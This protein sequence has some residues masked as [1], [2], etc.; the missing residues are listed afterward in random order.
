MAFVRV[1]RNGTQDPG[2]CLLAKTK[3]PVCFRKRAVVSPSGLWGHCARRVSLQKP[4]RSRLRLTVLG[5]RRTLLVLG[6]ELVELFLVLG[7]AQPIEEILEFGL[8]LLEALQRLD[9]VFIEGAIAARGRAETAEAE[10]AALHVIAHPLHLVRPAVLV[11]PA[12]HFSAPE[13]E[14]EKGKADRPPDDEAEHGDGDPAGVPG[15]IK[16]MRAVGLLF[17]AAPSIDICGVGHF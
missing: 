9:A 5:R 12:S 6:H 3:P 8:L 1:K 4:S 7:V 13:C 2:S 16:H 14:K 10:A 17:G 15:R 11:A